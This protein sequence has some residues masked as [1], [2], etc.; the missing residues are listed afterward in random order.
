[1]TTKLNLRTNI[2]SIQ[3][4]RHLGSSTEALR[5]SFTRLSS[6]LRINKASDD[7]AGLSISASLKTD[8]RVFAQGVRNINDGISLLNIAE[9]AVNELGSIITRQIELAEQAANGVMSYEQRNALELEAQALNKEYNRI[10]ETT[11]FNGMSLLTEAGQNFN[12][13]AG[14]SQIQFSLG[15]KM[16]R[17]VGDGTFQDPL[18]IST[19]TAYSVALGD[20]DGDGN[21]DI[22]GGSFGG[23]NAIRVLLGNGDGSF[24]NDFSYESPPGNLGRSAV[25]A[26]FNGDDSLD[27][28]LTSQTGNKLSIYLNNGD[29]SFTTFGNY[30]TGAAPFDVEASDLNGDNIIDLVTADRNGGRISVFIGNGNGSFKQAITYGI[31]SSDLSLSDF[32]GDG[33]TDI[34]SSSDSFLTIRVLIGNG[35]GTFSFHP[36][37]IQ[38][39]FGTRND[40][41]DFNGD[42]I[43]DFAIANTGGTQT[44]VFIGNGD[45][46]FAQGTNYAISAVSSDISIGDFN[47]D[48]NADLALLSR[49]TGTI[50]ILAGNGDGTFTAFTTRPLSA[51]DAQRITIGDVNNDDVLDLVSVDVTNSRFIVN[52]G[53]TRK[54]TSQASVDLRTQKSARESLETLREQLTRTTMEIGNIGASQSRLSTASNVMRTTMED[55]LSAN[56]QITDVDV[57]EESATLARQQILQ[58]AAVA[59]LAQ[60]NQQ[61]SLILKLLKN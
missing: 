20:L 56:S 21:E 14:Y 22:V 55:Y 39:N 61:P 12:I 48:N 49:T 8:S 54:V 28:A 57:A 34:L 38:T 18:S 26:D 59:I 29:G 44:T 23:A 15:D 24:N 40:I 58:Q 50:S 17:L 27:I 19:S 41:G 51:T 52:I 7:A 11:S 53:N 47:G 4:Q 37:L 3:T 1:L 10:V 42:G 45:G 36:Q 13:Q 35:D 31:Q 30:V 60:A 16:S 6:G 9:G 46:S 33:I 32:N 25:I 43:M 5:D 2:A